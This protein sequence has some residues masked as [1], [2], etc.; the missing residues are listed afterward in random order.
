MPED[1]PERFEQLLPWALA[2]GVEKQWAS[3]FEEVLLASGYEPSWYHGT[4]PW[5]MAGP[6]MIT[7]GLS[8]GLGQ[9]ISSAATPPGSSSGFGGGGSSGGGGGGGGGG[10][11]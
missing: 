10:G 6:S 5:H 7:S 2:L 3:R 1:T 11:W 9:A 4:T 8:S